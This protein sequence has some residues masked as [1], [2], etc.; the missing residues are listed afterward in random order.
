MN[1]SHVKTSHSKKLLTEN[2]S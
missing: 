1:I 2:I